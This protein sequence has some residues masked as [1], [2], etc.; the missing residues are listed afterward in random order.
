MKK[1]FEKE[2]ERRTERTRRF[3]L[4][5]IESVRLWERGVENNT[6]LCDE[7]WSITYTT[8]PAYYIKDK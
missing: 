1:R 8:N 5:K 2:Q 6:L 7:L 4:Q 3:V